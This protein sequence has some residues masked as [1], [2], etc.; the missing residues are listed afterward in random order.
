MALRYAARTKATEGVWDD[1]AAALLVGSADTDALSAAI[2]RLNG[3]LSRRAAWWRLGTGRLRN[4]PPA[5]VAEQTAAYYAHA[6][7]GTGARLAKPRGRAVA[8]APRSAHM[9]WRQ[10]A[11]W[12]R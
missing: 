4:L 5:P 8:R 12:V 11:A 10:W 2:E 3:D 6:R 1:G 9:Q 7:R